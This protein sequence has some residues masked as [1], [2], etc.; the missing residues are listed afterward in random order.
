MSPTVHV[1]KTE[2][3]IQQCWEAGPDE[4]W[5]DHEGFAHVSG[6]MVYPGSGIVMEGEHLL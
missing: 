1:L 6:L 3:P 2:F 5:L 4:G